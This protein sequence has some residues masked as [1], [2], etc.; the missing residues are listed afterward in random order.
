MKHLTKEWY[1]CES[2]AYAGKGAKILKFAEHK[3]E[4]LFETLYEKKLEIL[5]EAE[6]NSEFYCD[7]KVEL[8]KLD[9]RINEDGIS[10]Q[11]RE[12][13]IDE[14]NF[15]MIANR[16]RLQSGKY[17]LFD[18]THCRRT[19]ETQFKQTLKLLQYL[20][21][22]IKDKVADMRVLALGYAS[23]EVRKLLTKHCNKLMRY[24]KREKAKSY[25]E[26]Y[27]TEL[28]LKDPFETPFFEGAFID[29]IE[30]KNGSL[31]I[32]LD[33]DTFIIV[34]NARIT[35]DELIEIYPFDCGAPHTKYSRIA[36]IELL[37]AKSNF[38]LHLL[39]EN[40]GEYGETHLLNF[41]VKGTNVRKVDF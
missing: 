9:E 36:A 40:C 22:D 33:C 38:A 7:P 6:S 25:E 41:T 23:S 26:S 21:Y 10:R 8:F 16:K 19:F 32:K 12:K 31:Y 18:I 35:E 14:K 4:Y 5:L 37:G 11:E 27:R 30:N 13:R 28:L 29:E 17:Y 15:F 34:S 3:S 1:I 20:P 24:C 39:V 2:L